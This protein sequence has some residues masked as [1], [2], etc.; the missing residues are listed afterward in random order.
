MNV[1]GKDFVIIKNNG[2]P[3]YHFANV[4]D[5]HLMNISHVI[6]GRELLGNTPKHIALYK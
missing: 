6:R 3:T 1:D 5:D 4:I 2:I